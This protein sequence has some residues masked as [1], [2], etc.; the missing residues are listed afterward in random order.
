MDRDHPLKR[1]SQAKQRSKSAN[2]FESG[3][4]DRY[5][6]DSKQMQQESVKNNDLDVSPS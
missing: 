5:L 2:Y 1:S 6:L 3:E 4:F